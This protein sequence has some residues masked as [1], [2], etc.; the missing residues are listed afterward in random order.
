M[1]N[2]R[3]ATLASCRAATTSSDS[4]V[5][6]EVGSSSFPGAKH[7]HS[8]GSPLHA[9]QPRRRE[10]LIGGLV[11]LFVLLAAAGSGAQSTPCKQALSLTDLTRLLEAGVAD[12]R[13]QQLVTECGVSFV[14]D[15]SAERRLHAAGA[16]KAVIALAGVKTQAADTAAASGHATGTTGAEWLEVVRDE[17]SIERKVMEYLKARGMKVFSNDKSD[18]LMVFLSFSADESTPEFDIAID[19]SE[20]AR[21]S[22][23]RVLQVSL[24][25]KQ[26]VSQ[27]RRDEVLRAINAHHRSY[28]A[29]RFALDGEDEIVGQ[30]SINIPGAAYPVHVE[31]VRDAVLRLVQSWGELHK[32]VK[33]LVARAR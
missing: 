5:P 1:I 24:L 10:V 6:G 4:A 11:T 18:D 13:M 31:L 21:A 25:S 32:T 22:S 26:L 2:R 28:W 33:P 27:S 3:K 30:W 23:E 19:T 16:S 12:Q 8:S 29:G 14:V 7:M 17:S 15:G 20:S 9:V